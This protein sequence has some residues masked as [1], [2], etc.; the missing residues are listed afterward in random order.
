MDLQETTK[1]PGTLVSPP[2]ASRG[3][4]TSVVI[5]AV[6]EFIEGMSVTKVTSAPGFRI[7]VKT[8]N[9]ASWEWFGN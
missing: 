2:V 6:P 1:T 5:Y 9:F 7:A 4:P 8:A 3:T